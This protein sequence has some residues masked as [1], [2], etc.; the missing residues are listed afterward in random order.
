[1][2][3]LP[4]K[5]TFL[6]LT[7]WI[8]LELDPQTQ[9]IVTTVLQIPASRAWGDPETLGLMP[10]NTHNVRVVEVTVPGI[11][12]EVMELG[13][14]SRLQISRFN[15]FSQELREHQRVGDGWDRTCQ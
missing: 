12:S 5:A 10:P 2:E 6:Q 13:H 11:P 7:C 4:T 3:D 9:A 8:G 14:T 15:N 1:M